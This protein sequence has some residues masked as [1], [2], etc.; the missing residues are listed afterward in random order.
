[1][2]FVMVPVP[3]EYVTDVMQLVVD[4]TRGA[5]R[6]DGAQPDGPTIEKFFL[7]ADEASR[8][9]LSAIARG[10]LGGA[11]VTD[12]YAAGVLQC[13]IQDTVAIIEQ[14][15]ATSE[16]A[17]MPALITRQNHLLSMP[18]DVARTIRAAEDE[19]R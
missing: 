13:E 1:M 15:N 4:M 6:Q 2:P 8:S 14:I 16:R 3:E 7:D 12:D 9:L 11:A 17:G 18:A 5:P 10:V 19:E